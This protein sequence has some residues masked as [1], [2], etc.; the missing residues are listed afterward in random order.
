MPDDDR[1]PVWDDLSPS[2]QRDARLAPLTLLL[3]A[4]LG[5]LVFW[6]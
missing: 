2:E 4:L 5:Y 1:L 3:L 6:T